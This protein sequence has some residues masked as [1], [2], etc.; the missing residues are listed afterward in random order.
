V[1]KKAQLSLGK[2]AAYTVSVAVLSFNIIQDR[3]FLSHLEEHMQFPI[4][5]Q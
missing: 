1:N 3:R 5:D 2:I 4:N